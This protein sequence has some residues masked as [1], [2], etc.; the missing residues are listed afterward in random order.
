MPVS[1]D[2]SHLGGRSQVQPG[3]AATLVGMN[4]PLPEP[5]APQTDTATR[6]LDYL[7]FY[8]SVVTAKVTGLS[9][10]DLRTSRLPSGWTPIELVKHLVFMER[11][12][13]RWGF[14][15]EQVPDPW[16][17]NGPE[18]RWAVDLD[19]SLDGLLDALRRGGEQTRS[20]VEGAGLR[21]RA[22]VGGRFATAADAPTLEWILFHVLQEYARHTGHLDI[23]RELIDG[24]TGED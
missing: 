14:R 19:E 8:R 16:G 9:D 13:L 18:D 12:W 22:A 21:D 10:E 1:F 4:L 6:F 15:G 3:R 24:A 23:A 17:D 20:I 5:A 11:R 7:D 2:C